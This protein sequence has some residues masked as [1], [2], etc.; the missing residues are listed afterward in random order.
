VTAG[1]L[2][3][4]L[5]MSQFQQP[6]LISL[7]SMGILAAILLAL[8][9]ALSLRLGRFISTPLLQLRVWLRDPHPYTPA[10]DRQD[11]IGDLARQLHARL[12]PPPP[13]EPEVEE[14][15]DFDDA[16]VAPRPPRAPSPSCRRLTTMTRPLP[17]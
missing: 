8:A 15:D 5:D 11:E 13:P 1:Q 16:P 3:I 12:A 17:A 4:S 2:R 7:Q 9:L 10:I 6:M 14:E